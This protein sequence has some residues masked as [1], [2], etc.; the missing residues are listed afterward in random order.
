MTVARL[1][2][3]PQMDHVDGNGQIVWSGPVQ[4]IARVR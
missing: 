2:A 3:A 1:M 4:E